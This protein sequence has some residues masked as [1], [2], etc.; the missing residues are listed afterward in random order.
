MLSLAQLELRQLEQQL[1]AQDNVISQGLRLYVARLY[2]KA[3]N[4]LRSIIVT[5]QAARKA[6]SL[7]QQ[8]PE[9]L[10]IYYPQ[11]YLR[12]YQREARNSGLEVELLLA[13]SRQ[14]SAFNATARGGAQEFGLMQLLPST[15]QRVAA[16]NDI[17]ITAPAQQ[18]LTP[19]LNIKLGALYLRDVTARYRH[20]L[21]A[22]IAAYNAGEE[23]ADA[24]T[25]RRAHPDPQVWIEL[26][27]FGT[28]RTY[29]K[30]VQRNLQVYQFLSL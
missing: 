9:Q 29:V 16:N 1:K 21:L 25:Q 19:A 13:I 4:Y 14:E 22:A 26:I 18:L 27:P 11:P 10:L 23:A 17:V 8:R 6:Q 24:W 5:T 15:A 20:N 2:A 28:T 3:D 12:I 7:W 30:R